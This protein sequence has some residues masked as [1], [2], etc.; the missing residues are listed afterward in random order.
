[1]KAVWL[2]GVGEKALQPM[3]CITPKLL[4]PVADRPL[5]AYLL[6]TLYRNGMREVYLVLPYTERRVEDFVR[7]HTPQG[8][9]VYVVQASD[10]ENSRIVQMLSEETA[11]LC[12]V[13][14]TRFWDFDLR[15]ALQFHADAD[16]DVTALFVKSEFF[17][18][19][20]ALL[21]DAAD[22]LT[23]CLPFF[24]ST[25]PPTA[26]GD[27]GV[28][29]LRP[30]C[31]TAVLQGAE[32]A[33]RESVLPRLLR[34]EAYAC[35]AQ[36][37]FNPVDNI[38]SFCA[39]TR[40]ILH[41]KTRFTLPHLANG[42]FSSSVLPKGNY[43]LIPPVFI[44]ENVTV[45][46]G[47]QIGPNTVLSDGCFVGA[48]AKTENSILCAGAA[49]YP[50]A[51]LRGA[52][53]CENAVVQEG[54]ELSVGSVV[55]AFA[56]V[57][58]YA[59]LEHGVRVWQHRAVESGMHVSGSV[60][61]SV[62]QEITFSE[63]GQLYT[64]S[65]VLDPIFLASFGSALG[66]C[67]FGKKVGILCDG[68]TAGTS[69]AQIVSGAL[70]AQGSGVWCF[71]KGFLPQLHFYTAFCDLQAGIFLCV[72]NGR[73]CLHLFAA[74]G[75]L[76]SGAQTAA[77]VARM[78]FGDFPTAVP[79]N[80]RASADMHDMQSMYLR[81]LLHEA[82]EMLNKQSVRVQCANEEITMLLED[83]LY[84]LHAE[85]GDDITLRLSYDGTR[86]TAF[87]RECGYLP[88]ERL[89]AICCNAV[90]QSGQDV[91]LCAD[92]PF[93]LEQFATE[94]GRRVLHYSALPN[95][96]TDAQTRTLARAQLYVRDGL[97]LCMRLLGILQQSGKS[98]AQ[99]HKALPE[100]FVRRKTVP[101][102][103][104]SEEVL[105]IL[106]LPNAELRDVGIVWQNADGRVL[107][108][109]QQA[110][111]RLCI[112]AESARFETAKSLCE[113]VEERLTKH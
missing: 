62:P 2:A 65:K 107:I 105:R 68:S 64:D 3:T 108:T 104:P 91:A 4:L 89:L 69:A 110:G 51:R 77:L 11:P 109:P 1:M 53:V 85:T 23:G 94:N 98:L 13:Y 14:G 48:Q 8:M 16:A 56:T 71:G 30:T 21:V 10:G 92:A 93:A 82:G 57:G 101:V 75:L 111:K 44:G 90:F 113:E 78:Q 50:R 45:A 7:Y 76:L 25:K 80:C 54:A 32:N 41:G 42:I 84:R 15:T 112:L 67:N 100:F 43:Q 66:G 40:D 27:S 46:D 22:K 19:G 28:Y 86:V 39:C 81:E 55:G 18:N 49:V 103:L 33:D 59:F 20:T 34:Y 96:E 60:R 99:L 73:L 63:T 38:A 35:A 52:V 5:L 36:G 61:N 83:A 87:H 26:K 37:Y 106:H 24:S 95:A 47:A 70:S 72:R 88:Y 29:L 17:R 58:R 102:Q 6:E 79:D 9:R 74:G 31:L 97:F 12:L